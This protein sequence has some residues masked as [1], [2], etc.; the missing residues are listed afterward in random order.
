MC[1]SQLTLC[2]WRCVC[3]QVHGH[4][5]GELCV[6]P[7]AVVPAGVLGA[8]ISDGDGQRSG[9]RVDAQCVLV[10]PGG[11]ASG[12]THVRAAS[13]PLLHAAPQTVAVETLHLH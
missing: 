8:Q 9:L 1:P 2:D 12:Q 6:P 3:L 5:H 7:G 4:K 10:Q 13:A 11:S